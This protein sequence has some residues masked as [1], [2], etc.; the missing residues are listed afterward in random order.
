MKTNLDEVCTRTKARRGSY[1]A[2]HLS[3]LTLGLL[4]LTAMCAQAETNFPVANWVCSKENGPFTTIA[5]ASNGIVYGGVYG[6]PGYPVMVWNGT[7]W[8]HL[9][10]DV[11][12]AEALAFDTNGSLYVCGVFSSPPIG[13]WTGS[14]WFDVGLGI[15]GGVY[16]MAFDTNGD[17]YAGG[18]FTTTVGG[19]PANNIAKRNGS[20][21]S[22]L[23]SGMNSGV[24][25]LAFDRNG[26]LYA[27]GSFTNAGGTSANLIAEWNG[28]GW[29]PLGT[30]MNTTTPY[31]YNYV[32]ALAFDAAGNLYAGGNF[33]TAGGMPAKNIAKWDGTNWSA[34]DS[35][36]NGIVNA[37]ACDGIGN[38]YA[39]GTFTNTGNVSADYIAKWNGTAW[40]SLN[41]GLNGFVTT[42]V[43]DTN[44]DI[45]VGGTF[46]TAGTNTNSYVGLT[47]V[48]I[49][50]SSHN[51]SLVKPSPGT[52]VITALGT[53]NFAYALD[54]ATNLTP[55][56]NWVP[57][58]TNTTSSTNLIFTNISAGPQGFYRTRFV[59]Q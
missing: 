48:L 13:K 3:R 7:S 41:S 31:N 54:L 49:S 46:T 38:L 52:N 57:Q 42:L 5:V 34:L 23:A 12:Q 4:A 14:N 8:G 25:A 58:A 15:S 51:L 28:T 59:S 40:S 26:N 47:K 44:Q 21:W 53:P 55:P 2:V 56:V 22:A 18:D 29:L 11:W 19:M 9:G 35:G 20:T 10:P 45:Y 16:A 37:L 36:L 17:L 50:T 1:F 43:F 6:S 27:G 33:T 24:Y 32:F 39:G 30:G